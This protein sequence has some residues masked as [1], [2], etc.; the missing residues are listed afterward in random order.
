MDSEAEHVLILVDS[1]YAG[2]LDMELAS[3]LQDLSSDRRSMESLA[4]VT[5]GDFT[6]RPR[7]GEFTEVI[8][9]A[10]DRISDEASGFANSI[11]SFQEWEHV[12]RE[13]ARERKDLVPVKWVWPRSRNDTP[14]PCLPNLGYWARQASSAESASPIPEGA[15][16]ALTA[17]S[18]WISRASGSVGEDDE[19]WYFTGRKAIVESTTEFFDS[20]DGICIVTGE[21]GSGKSAILAQLVVHGN[22]RVRE[23][24][25]KRRPS[26]LINN[27]FPEI[28][29]ALLA[30]NKSS[31]AVMSEVREA[32]RAIVGADAHSAPPALADFVAFTQKRLDRPLTIVIDGVDEAVEPEALI[33]DLLLPLLRRANGERQNV[34]ALLGVR[35]PRPSGPAKAD[36]NAKTLVDD[37][38]DTINMP[39]KRFLEETGAEVSTLPSED[40]EEVITDWTE[41]PA[42][43]LRTDDEESIP[44]VE[45]YAFRLLVDAQQENSPYRRNVFAAREVALKIAENVAPS[46]LNAR[47][48]ADTARKAPHVQDVRDQRWLATLQDGTVA[49]LYSDVEE[50]AEH[51]GIPSRDLLAGLQ[52]TAFSCGVGLP[53]SD[54]WP[55]VYKAIH[56]STSSDVDRAL[57]T[58]RSGRLSGYLLTDVSDE[59]M[60][61]RPSHERITEELKGSAIRYFFGEGGE[62]MN[63]DRE[64]VIQERIASALADL[65]RRHLPYAPHPYIRR[66][67]I[68]HAARGLVLDDLHIPIGFLEWETSRLIGSYLTN[69]MPQS[70]NRALYA[71][72]RMERHLTGIDVVS[73]RGSHAFHLTA[74]GGSP[75]PLAGWIHPE[76]VNWRSASSEQGERGSFHGWPTATAAGRL[77]FVSSGASSETV[78]VRDALDGHTE[79]RIQTGPIANMCAISIGGKECVATYP[80]Y[81]QGS[82]ADRCIEI[83]DPITSAKIR[84]ISC[85]RIRQ[86]QTVFGGGAPAVAAICQR[87]GEE[88]AV[89]NPESGDLL[90]RLQGVAAGSFCDLG[91]V[92]KEEVIAVSDAPTKDARVH[93]WSPYSGK[94][95]RSFV[96]GPVGALVKVTDG[97]GRVML[98]TLESPYGNSE[99]R[100]WD[101]ETGNLERKV[102]AGPVRA[103]TAVPTGTG[104][105]FLVTVGADNVI[106]LFDLWSG[107]EIENLVTVAP[108]SELSSFFVDQEASP[109]IL[110]S[111]TAGTAALSLRRK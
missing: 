31:A 103:M 105:E 107:R 27:P 60:V 74:L 5:S 101:I 82:V 13:I 22:R 37:L 56:P 91:Q 12:L 45:S 19:S 15:E 46:F 23:A 49:L 104:R 24:A 43:L 70:K 76:W 84:R 42:L 98:A 8:E 77:V 63:G 78:E 18:Y 69:Q 47:L 3:H 16:T 58:L 54:V 85:G 81:G 95:I 33:A 102:Q 97:L 21:A 62:Q 89:W 40:E 87:F 1:C 88:V 35:S 100:L 109:R 71:W 68:E 94:V 32:L 20:G 50:V 14:S 41:V 90:A 39:P 83:W 29:I 52:S 55:A 28:D 111:G 79:S 75:P 26:E 65:V 34:R 38:V 92:G 25:G 66:Y 36:V 17:P 57:R 72:A 61:Y 96:T 44:E 93:V 2:T 64:T 51:T 30:R 4:V 6:D 59:R 10:M 86:L 9:L 53:W 99:I 67:L 108:V 106:S 110:L 73:Q 48:A 80:L 11:I 7:V